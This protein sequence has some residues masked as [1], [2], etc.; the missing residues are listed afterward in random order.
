MPKIKSLILRTIGLVGA[1]AC[2]GI[3]I[4]DPSFPTPDKLI[5]FLFFVFLAV[6][7]AIEMLL[8]LGPFV[9]WL[10]V[11]ESFRSVV[12]HLN[13]HV[14]YSLAPHADRLLFGRLPTKSLQNWLW[15]GHTSWYD[16]ALYIP[17]LLFFVIPF[18]LALL[19]WKTREKYYWRVVCTYIVVFFS[20]YLTFLLY[21]A[22]P[23]WLAAQNHFIEPLTRVSSSVWFSLGIHDFPSF[24]NHLAPNPVAAIPSLHAACA[25][26][27]TLFVFKLYGRRWGLLSAIYPLMIYFG[28]VY[29]GEHYVFDVIC[30]VAYAV[31][32]YALTPHLMRLG[33]RL[34]PE[35]F[36][37]KRMAAGRLR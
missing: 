24:Y 3:F 26:L 13:N 20:G 9:V 34:I 28:V 10:L 32:G 27:L 22:A 18:G 37:M 8:R 2:I 17:Y 31:A 30:G 19:V 15:K 36:S 29:E 21:P 33:S 35:N 1:A 14:H 23:P 16:I 5:I 25:T 12:P 11:Y 4:A 7:Q 6:E